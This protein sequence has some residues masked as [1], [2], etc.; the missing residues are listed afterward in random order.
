MTLA[1]Y[2]PRD[3]LEHRPGERH[4]E[5]PERLAAVMC[6]LEAASDLDLAPNDAP[7]V[8]VA[9]LLTVHDQAYLETIPPPPGEHRVKLDPDTLVSAGSLTGARR[10]AGT[11]VQAVRDVA[12]CEAELAFCAVRPS[13]HHAEP[14]AAM[15]LC[16]LSNVA[17]AAYAAQ[18]AGLLRVAVVATSTSITATARRRPWRVGRGCSWLLI[19]Q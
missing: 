17:A 3:M 6:A 10:A 7:M 4:V 12:A 14:D 8:D 19:E 9:D 16:I 1:F 11:V 18:A 5:R 15:G 13:G 2:T